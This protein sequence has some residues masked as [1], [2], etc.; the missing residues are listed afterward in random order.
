MD[1]SY[2][3]VFGSR[4]SRSSHVLSCVR[5]SSWYLTYLATRHPSAW[6]SRTLQWI[7]HRPHRPCAYKSRAP[8]Q[9]RP[10]KALFIHIGLDK[11]P[12]YAVHAMMTFPA[13]RGYSSGPLFLFVNGSLSPALFLQIGLGRSWLQHRYRAIPSPLA[14]VLEL[15]LSLLAVGFWINGPLAQQRLSALY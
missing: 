12:L 4:P 8:R 11:H 7:L 2:L 10:G 13:S 15:P 6:V 3:A 14:F 1:A 5:L 9:T